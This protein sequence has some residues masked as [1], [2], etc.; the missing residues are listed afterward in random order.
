GST[1][2]PV[3]QL[4]APPPAAGAAVQRIDYR[5]LLES[6]PAVSYVAELSSSC[7]WHFVSPQIEELTGY[8]V[9]E[10]LADPGLWFRLVHPEDR[11]AVLTA[12]EAVER[13]GLPFA[14]E[15]RLVHRSGGD[16]WVR[17]DAVVRM[18]ADGRC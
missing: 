9:D 16:R 7:D 1:V 5:E 17:D 13:E 18:D 14:C 2:R 3:A 6:I 8:T 10:W 4:A 12:E 15:Y 11:E